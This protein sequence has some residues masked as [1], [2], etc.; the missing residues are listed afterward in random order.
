MTKHKIQ[1]IKNDIASTWKE[2]R[3]RRGVWLLM[4]PSNFLEIFFILAAGLAMPFIVLGSYFNFIPKAERTKPWA[5]FFLII[6]ILYAI[7]YAYFSWRMIKNSESW[8]D[9]TKNS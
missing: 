9:L 5:I 6:S 8:K 7:T 1:T 4:K 3:F 2:G